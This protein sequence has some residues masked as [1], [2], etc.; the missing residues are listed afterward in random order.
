MATI[1]SFTNRYKLWKV[2]KWEYLRQVQEAFSASEIE[3]QY[4]KQ[5][6]MKG[7]MCTILRGTIACTE[8]IKTFSGSQAALISF[9][10]V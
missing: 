9:H 7:K 8:H 10:P 1:C 5:K 6:Y 4:P 3:S 2:L